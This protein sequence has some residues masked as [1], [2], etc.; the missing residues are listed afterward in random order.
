MPDSV[1]T[2]LHVVSK[3]D[4]NKQSIFLLKEMWGCGSPVVK[5]LDHDRHVISSSPLKTHRVRERCTLNLSRARTSSRW[6]GV[7]VSRGWCQLSCRLRHLTVVE[8]DEV[9]HQKPPCS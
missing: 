9:H 5:I 6:C 8:K 7:V 1:V 4:R 3:C 2:N